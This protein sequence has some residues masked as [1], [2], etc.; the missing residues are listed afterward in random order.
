MSADKERQERVLEPPLI[1]K[2]NYI[3]CI[4]DDLEKKILPV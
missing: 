2:F 1:L 3:F 4:F